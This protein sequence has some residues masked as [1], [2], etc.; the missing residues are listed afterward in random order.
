LVLAAPIGAFFGALA[1]YKVN[2][3]PFMKMLESAFT[4]YTTPR[5]FI[6]KK[7]ERG[8]ESLAANPK[9]NYR[10]TVLPPHIN[11]KSKDLEKI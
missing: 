9:T 4:H 11:A 3:Q 6:W 8:D 10:E 5:L 1:F 2:G 7:I